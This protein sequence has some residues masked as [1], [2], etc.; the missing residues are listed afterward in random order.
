MNPEDWLEKRD[1][2]DMQLCN[3]NSLDGEQIFASDAIR[4]YTKEILNELVK[5]YNQQ[6]INA[7]RNSDTLKSVDYLILDFIH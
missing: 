4:M 3:H 7:L 6:K 5:E 1:L 2:R